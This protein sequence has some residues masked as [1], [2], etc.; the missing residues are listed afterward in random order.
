MF[1]MTEYLFMKIYLTV[2]PYLQL[3][4]STSTDSVIWSP[5]PLVLLLKGFYKEVLQWTEPV[6]V[7]ESFTEIM[8]KDMANGI[9]G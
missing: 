5:L 2:D 9:Q 3:T 6:P 1:L 8:A 4:D 7:S